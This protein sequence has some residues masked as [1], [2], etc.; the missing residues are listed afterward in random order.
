MSLLGST[1]PAT[2]V[3][4]ALSIAE[5]PTRIRL[6]AGWPF[7]PGSTCWAITTKAPPVAS[8]GVLPTR[9]VTCALTGPIA[10]SELSWFVPAA[11]ASRA[12]AGGEASTGTVGIRAPMP[13]LPVAVRSLPAGIAGNG[14]LSTSAA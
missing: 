2:A 10:Y 5:P 14:V 8:A 13:P 4:W 6:G 7:G 9:P 1:L 3:S 12:A 11:A